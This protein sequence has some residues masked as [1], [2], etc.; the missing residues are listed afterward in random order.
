MRREEA[1]ISE[2]L[3]VR[4]VGSPDGLVPL[5]SKEKLKFAMKF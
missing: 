5:R 4:S 3:G 2:E 1:F